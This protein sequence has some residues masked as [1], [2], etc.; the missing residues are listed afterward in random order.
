MKPTK[1]SEKCPFKVGDVVVYKPSQRGHAL[2][3]MASQQLQIGEKYKI[4]SVVDEK[5]VAVEGYSHPG[6]GLYWTEFSTT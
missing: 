4:S 5:Y 1:S 3:V 6:G 2:D